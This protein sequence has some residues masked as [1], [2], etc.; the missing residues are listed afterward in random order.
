[1]SVSVGT[2]GLPLVASYDD[3][4]HALVVSHCSNEL[5]LPYYRRR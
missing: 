1:M 4:G 2:D 3:T 5:C